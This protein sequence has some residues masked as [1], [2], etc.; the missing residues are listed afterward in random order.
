MRTG[1]DS[2]TFP[3]FLRTGVDIQADVHLF[4][5]LILFILIVCVPVLMFRPT[6]T[7][8]VAPSPT[9]PPSLP[10]TKPFS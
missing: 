9:H 7:F 8:P 1:V 10:V 2:G 5:F 6:Y 3:L 4:L